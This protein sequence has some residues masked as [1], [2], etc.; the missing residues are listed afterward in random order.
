MKEK[1]WTFQNSVLCRLDQI[2]KIGCLRKGDWEA[3]LKFLP[4][5]VC[6]LVR[7]KGDM[8]LFSVKIY[9]YTCSWFSLWWS[10]T[11]NTSLP[12]WRKCTL[13]TKDRNLT[14]CQIHRVERGIWKCP[15]RF[16]C[17]MII[18]SEEV[19]MYPSELATQPWS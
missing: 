14:K 15:P 1:L 8:V 18:S 19:V 6:L 16:I 2:K 12:K 9:F 5:A 4:E 10:Y 7:F 11:E 17:V 3:I 13:G